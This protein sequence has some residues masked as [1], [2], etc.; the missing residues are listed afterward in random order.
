MRIKTSNS[1][2]NSGASLIGDKDKLQQLSAQQIDDFSSDFYNN[3][4]ASFERF[5]ATRYLLVLALEIIIPV[6]TAEAD[7][8]INLI[9]AIGSKQAKFANRKS[10]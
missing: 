1:V 6:A 10:I 3:S 5:E 9:A 7:K 2:S 4:K 8:I